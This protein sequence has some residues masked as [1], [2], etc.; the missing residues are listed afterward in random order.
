MADEDND[1]PDLDNLGAEAPEEESAVQ[2]LFRI[3]E[4]SRIAVGRATGPS[5]KKQFD[6]ATTAYEH[7]YTV[8]D[9][10][11]RYYNNDQNKDAQGPSGTFHRGDGTENIIFSNINVMLPAIYSK[12]PDITCST[13]DEADQPF[14]DAAEALCNVLLK[15]KDRLHAKPKVKKAGG[16]GLLTNHGVLKLDFEKKDDSREFAVNEMA[17]ITDEL[18]KAKTQQD[19]ERLYG[20]LEALEANMEVLLP[21]GFSLSNVLPQN[22]IIDPNAEQADGMDAKWMIERVY[23]PTGM[24]NAR[25]TKKISEDADDPNAGASVLV[26]KPT[27]KAIFAPGQGGE[28]ED[29]LGLVMQALDGGGNLPTAHTDEERAAYIS[30]FYTECFYVWDR[31]M[32]RVMLF[33]RDDWTWPLWVWDDPLKTSRF[34]PYYIVAFSL[35]TGGTVSAGENAYILDQ[36]DEINEINREKTR[37]RRAIFNFFFYNSE[38]IDEEEAQKFVN[39]IRGISDGSNGDYLLGVKAGESKIGDLIESLAPPAAQYESLFDKGP[40]LESINRVT[41]TSD[42]LRGTQFKTNTNVASVKSYEQSMRISVGAKVDVLED[43]VSDIANSII[44]I[45]VQNWDKEEVAAIIGANLAEGWEQMDLAKLQST[46]NV[47]VVA[48]SMEKPTS[49]FKKQEAIEI[50]QAVGQFAQAAPVSTLKIMLRVLEKAFTEVVIKPED[51]DAIDAET[52]A[53]LAGQAPG[54]GQ[55]AGGDSTGDVEAL[56]EQAANLP[57]EQQEE[58]VRMYESGASNE[59]LLAFV[60]QKITEQGTGANGTAKR[61]PGKRPN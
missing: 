42:A 54:S 35:S 7:I 3:F 33:H 56:K 8:W 28:R 22:L 49:A 6:A 43:V 25:Y 13:T 44:E 47:E 29:G 59:E 32:R 17:R 30:E 26:Y 16:I 52:T 50:T 4:G 31:V 21:S 41:N 55:P 24:L 61:E 58:F 2:P 15:K 14:C 51:W 37:I 34:F 36:Q 19:V 45:A 23:L 60:Q 40:A 27:H 20:E 11:F 1:L 10:C 18:S 9:E 5:W 48:G 53:N 39:V 57:P 38:K 12:D 46:F